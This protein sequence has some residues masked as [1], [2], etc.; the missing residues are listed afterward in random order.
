MMD[1]EVFLVLFCAYHTIAI[2]VVTTVS[3][4]RQAYRLRSRLLQKFSCLTENI[5]DRR[6]RRL[7]FHHIHDCL[8][9]L[10][11]RTLGRRIVGSTRQDLLATHDDASLF[12]L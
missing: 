10:I 9:G 4:G 6:D 3:R 1:R 7:R 11:H 5:A 8:F 12:V 2:I